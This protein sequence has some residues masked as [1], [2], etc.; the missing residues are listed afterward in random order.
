MHNLRSIVGTSQL[1]LRFPLMQDDH[2]S[3]DAGPLAL[4]V[5]RK[6]PLRNVVAIL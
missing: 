5:L 2:D 4:W 3:F 1:I 6:E